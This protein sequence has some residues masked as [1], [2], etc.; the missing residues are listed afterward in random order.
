MAK[1]DLKSLSVPDAEWDDFRRYLTDLFA[2]AAALAITAKASEIRWE[3]ERIVCMP[4][5]RLLSD[6][7]P[8]F[9]DKVSDQP[10]AVI[11]LHTLKLAYHSAADD[12]QEFY[13]T[14]DSDDLF[15]MHEI[16]ERAIEKDQSLRT[17][18][19]RAGL[20]CLEG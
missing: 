13:V 20:A 2:N 17:L 6:M 5:C 7:R 3:N 10:G 11:V 16:I 8:I 12:V 1:R 14:M 15:L 18:L 19:E 9:A 4:G